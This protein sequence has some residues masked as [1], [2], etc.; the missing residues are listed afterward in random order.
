MKDKLREAKGD[1]KHAFLAYQTERIPRTTRVQN[2]ARFAGELFH[3]QGAGRVF[4]NLLLS[5][6]SEDDTEYLDWVW[7][8]RGNNTAAASK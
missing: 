1:L 3:V 2:A 8:Y 7:G 5:K 6:R 4:R